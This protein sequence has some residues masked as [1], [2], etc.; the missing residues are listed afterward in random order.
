[1]ARPLRQDDNVAHDCWGR[2]SL[3]VRLPLDRSSAAKALKQLGR[4]RRQ[5]RFLAK[6]PHAE[7]V[8]VA[9]HDEVA[10]PHTSFPLLC[11]ILCRHIVDVVRAIRHSPSQARHPSSQIFGKGAA[12]SDY[13]SVAIDV[14][15]FTVNNRSADAVVE[16]IGGLLPAAVI[17]A[18]CVLSGLA[19]FRCVHA[20]E[21]NALTANFQR[22]PVR[23]PVNRIF[24]A[25]LPLERAA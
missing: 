19:T 12:A 13:A 2:P 6:K 24:N 7:A 4:L 16:H 20:V 11:Q 14:Q 23:G 1:M 10:G 9:R 22:V 18:A 25:L 21:A 17:L 5:Q 8:P 3:P 15:W